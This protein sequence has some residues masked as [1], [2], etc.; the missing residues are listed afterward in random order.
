MPHALPSVSPEQVALEACGLLEVLDVL[1][2]RGGDAPAPVPVSASQLRVL[3]V[4]EHWEGTNLRDLGEALGSTPPSVSRLCDR[5]E[6]AGL[7]QRSRG[8]A[9]R[10]EVELRLSPGGRRMLAQ[11][12]TRRSREI[13]TVLA[14]IPP[15]HLTAVAEGLQAFRAA[16]LTRIGFEGQDEDSA[17]A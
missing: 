4:I 10:R 12:R 3:T 13:E 15:G 17:T 5:L 7:L 1:W 16:A 9:N 8:T 14:M 6:A 11:M 2:G